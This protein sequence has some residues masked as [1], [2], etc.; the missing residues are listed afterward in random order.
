MKL[1]WRKKK[2]KENQ[3]NQKKE[4]GISMAGFEELKKRTEELLKKA[5]AGTPTLA[6]RTAPILVAKDEELRKREGK[7]AA[8]EKEQ[9]LREKALTTK[10]AVAKETMANLEEARKAIEERETKVKEREDAVTS[11][12]E[13]AQ[14][15]EGELNQRAAELDAQSKELD[16]KKRSLDEVATNQAQIDEALKVREVIVKVQEDEVAEVRALAG[17]IKRIIEEMNLQPELEAMGI[18]SEFAKYVG[19]EVK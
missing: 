19:E 13:T 15:K 18:W 6:E 5:S 16:E 3:K 2:A 11:Q 7:V 9:D 1:P 8:K 12:E 14:K 10:E 4:G 17:V